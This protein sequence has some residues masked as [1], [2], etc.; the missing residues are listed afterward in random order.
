MVRSGKPDCPILIRDTIG[1]GEGILLP[2][3]WYLTWW[4]NKI[5]DNFGGCG[6]G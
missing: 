1:S 3:K 5:H 4:K 6:G 2:A